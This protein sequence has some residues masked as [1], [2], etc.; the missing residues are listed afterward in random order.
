MKIA[1]SS[2]QSS[3]FQAPYSFHNH[4]QQPL[5]LPPNS[6]VAVQSLKINKTGAV[7]VNPATIWYQY[8]GV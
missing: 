1:G 5:K 8:F 7:T 6:E 3:D 2:V 4:L